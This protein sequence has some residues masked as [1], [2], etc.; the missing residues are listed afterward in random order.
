MRRSLQ[1]PLLNPALV[2]PALAQLRL[3]DVEVRPRPNDFSS[4]IRCTSKIYGADSVEDWMHLILAA[5]GLCLGC[6]CPI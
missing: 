4:F 2:Y 1:S 5:A 6:D 3:V